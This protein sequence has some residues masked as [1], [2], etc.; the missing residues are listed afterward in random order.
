MIRS[1]RQL[2]V[3]N[4]PLTLVIRDDLVVVVLPVRHHEPQAGQEVDHAEGHE[5][6]E[7]DVGQEAVER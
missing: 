6:E 1:G 5:R 7:L 2:S 4:I 3:Q